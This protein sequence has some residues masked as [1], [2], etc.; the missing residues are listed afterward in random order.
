MLGDLKICPVFREDAYARILEVVDDPRAFPP[1]YREFERLIEDIKS[2][3]A[4]K[5]KNIRTRIVDAQDFITY[6]DILRIAVSFENA[7]I[8]VAE[9]DRVPRLPR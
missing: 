9:Q 6:C 1:T 8:Y 7:V 4:R 5:G 3:S 2:A